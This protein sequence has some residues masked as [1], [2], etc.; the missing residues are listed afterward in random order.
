MLAGPRSVLPQLKQLK[1]GLS[2]YNE[3]LMVVLT[4]PFPGEVVTSI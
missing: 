2:A 1:F 3:G 4:A